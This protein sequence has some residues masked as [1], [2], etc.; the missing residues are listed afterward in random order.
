M[1]TSV[2][3]IT[4]QQIKYGTFKHVDSWQIFVNKAI[5]VTTGS[6]LYWLPVIMT[7]KY[8]S[9]CMLGVKLYS[10]DAALKMRE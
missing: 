10:A 4:P 2:Y 6:C 8:D 3:R 7:F 1:Y 9:K 5:L